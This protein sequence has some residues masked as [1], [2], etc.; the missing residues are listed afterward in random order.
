MTRGTNPQ[1]PNIKLLFPDAPIGWAKNYLLSEPK[2]RAYIHDEL[3]PAAIANKDAIIA[4]PEKIETILREH[5]ARVGHAKKIAEVERKAGIAKTVM[6][7][8]EKE[9]ILFGKRF[10]PIVDK[11]QFDYDYDQLT[12]AWFTFNDVWLMARQF[13][14]R[15]RAWR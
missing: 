2:D 3:M 12:A 14:G 13:S 7:P 9:V 10:W 1:T 8:L 6:N 4:E 15:L 11:T 5:F